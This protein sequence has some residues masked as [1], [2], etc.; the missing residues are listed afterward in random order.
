MTVAIARRNSLGDMWM[1]MIYPEEEHAVDTEPCVQWCI[2]RRNCA[3]SLFSM[4]TALPSSA[5]HTQESS[6]LRPALVYARVGREGKLAEDAEDPLLCS[7]RSER[8][9]VYR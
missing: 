6:A 8:P 7:S 2:A 5:R 1:K 4:L 3:G 9:D